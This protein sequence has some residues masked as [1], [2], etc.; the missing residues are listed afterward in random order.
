LSINRLHKLYIMSRAKKPTVFIN[1]MRI[2]FQN[3]R[4]IRVKQIALRV[5]VWVN[6]NFTHGTRF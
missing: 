4:I 2:I 3:T 5:V 1:Y 6:N